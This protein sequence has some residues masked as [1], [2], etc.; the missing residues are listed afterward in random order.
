MNVVSNQIEKVFFLKYGNSTGTC[1]TFYDKNKEYLITAKHVINGIGSSGKIQIFHGNIWKNVAV[2]VLYHSNKNVDVAVMELNIKIL[3]NPLK[4]QYSMDSI[5]PGQDT[6]FLGFP[7]GL[8][9]NLGDNLLSSFPIPFIK[10]GTCSSI[11]KEN[12]QNILY[13]DGHNNP[14][15]SGGPVCFTNLFSKE[16]HIAGVVSAYKLNN[17]QQILNSQH[18]KTDLLYRENSGIVKCYPISCVNEIIDSN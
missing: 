13:L 8:F 9:S 17:P 10:K 4:I 18:E 14:G 15:F 7:Y 6:F 2:N 5:S 1:F 11:I 16:F 3:N 12:G